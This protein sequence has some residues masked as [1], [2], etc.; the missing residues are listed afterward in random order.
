MATPK[1]SPR[2]SPKLR[3]L[4]RKSVRVSIAARILGGVEPPDGGKAQKTTR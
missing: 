4:K 2:K 1:Q 3:T